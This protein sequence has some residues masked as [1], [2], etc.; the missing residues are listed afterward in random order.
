MNL[1]ISP[2]SLPESE[3]NRMDVLTGKRDAGQ[4]LFSAPP[5]SAPA[6]GEYVLIIDDDPA[7][8][9]LLATFLHEDEGFPVHTSYSVRHLLRHTPP[10]PPGLILLD[11]TLPDE[12]SDELAP[13]LRRLP[14][15]HDAPIVLCSG[16]DYLPRIARE[17]GA[18]AYLTKPFSLDEIAELANQY[19]PVVPRLSDQDPR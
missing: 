4:T 14:G 13:S 18:V 16:Q 1:W 15:W 8:V 9:D 6:S 7:I 3:E 19:V 12:D 11:I 5:V 2:H 10:T 17:A